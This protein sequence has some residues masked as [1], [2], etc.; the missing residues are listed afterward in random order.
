MSTTTI[1]II[2]RHLMMSHHHEMMSHAN[3]LEH[4]E[5][6]HGNQAATTPCGYKTSQIDQ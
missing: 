5:K 4:V 1:S 3:M 6:H 2:H